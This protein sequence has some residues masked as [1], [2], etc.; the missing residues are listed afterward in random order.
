MLASR[1]INSVLFFPYKKIYTKL[2][3]NVIT[4]L[5][6]KSTF[7]HDQRSTPS[8][9]VFPTVQPFFSINFLFHSILKCE[10]PSDCANVFSIFKLY[11]EKKG[12]INECC[13]KLKLFW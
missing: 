8:C 5:S 9:H 4:V 12:R 7:F 1:V 3:K 13:E 2:G 6:S 11:V 10:L